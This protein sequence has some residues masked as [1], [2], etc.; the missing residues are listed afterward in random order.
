MT[1]QA[2]SSP[3]LIMGRSGHLGQ[4][5]G[6]RIICLSVLRAGCFCIARLAEKCEHLR[7]QSVEHLD[8]AVVLLGFNG[9]LEL[10]EPFSE[11]AQAILLDLLEVVLDHSSYSNRGL[12]SIVSS[13][14]QSSCP[15]QTIRSRPGLMMTRLSSGRMMIV[16]T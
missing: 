10:L 6:E 8:Q 7:P 14:F 11:A 3:R 4:S 1:P 2:G 15:T 16:K 9:R 12:T 5:S 13:F